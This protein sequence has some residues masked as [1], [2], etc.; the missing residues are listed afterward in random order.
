MAA[1]GIDDR[2]VLIHAP[3]K[4]NL[5]LEVKAKRADGYHELET[6]MVGVSL[7][8]SL[9]FR[10]K[11]GG[12]LDVRCEVSAALG[13][14]SQSIPSGSANIAWQALDRLRMLTRPSQ[15]LFGGD[16]EIFKRIPDQA[17]LGGGSSD[18]AAALLAARVA[19][20]AP[21]SDDELSCIAA[22]V[23][24]DVPFFLNPTAALCQGRGEIV[25]PLRC[26]SPLWFVVVKPPV[27]LST[28]AVY[29]SFSPPRS[30]YFAE[31]L[32]ENLRVR[33][34][35]D[36]GRHMRNR[37]QSVAEELAP[38]IR[39]A[40]QAFAKLGCCGHQMSGS[41]TAYFGLFPNRMAAH[42]ATVLLRSRLHGWFVCCCHSLSRRRPIACRAKLAQE[43]QRDHH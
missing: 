2:F 1:T 21:A 26:R 24:S 23:G 38:E 27:G 18:A 6:V 13:L 5:F 17:G 16:L 35:Y 36:V 7:F 3:A 32:A 40:A 10:A 37:L 43:L 33:G 20:Q 15:S 19:W 29:A 34:P 41:G 30:P 14:A 8:D 25:T 11:S 4:L 22:E 42:R 28:Q 31:E 39:Q 9:R 12:Q